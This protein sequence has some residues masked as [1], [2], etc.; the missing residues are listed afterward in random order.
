MTRPRATTT[1]GDDPATASR[2]PERP[3]VR[4]AGAV[5]ASRADPQHPVQRHRAA[6]PTTSPASTS[7]RCAPSLPFAA[8]R[9]AARG[10]GRRHA[11]WRGCSTRAPPSTRPRSSQSCWSARESRSAPRSA[12]AGSGVDLDVAKRRLAEAL[13]LLR[14]ALAEPVFPAVRG[15]PHRQDPARRDRAG[16]RPRPA[17]GGAGVHRHATSTR[18]TGP[19]VRRPAPPRAIAA[20]TRQDIVDFHA[21]R[22]GP[23]GHDRRRRRRPARASTWPTW[24]R[25]HAG[26][27]GQRHATSPAPEPRGAAARRGRGPRRLRRP[28]RVGAERAAGGVGRSG[29]A[30]RGR[31]GGIP[32]PGVHRRRL[33]QRARRRGAARGEGLHLRHPLGASGR[34]GV[35]GLFLTSGSVRADATVESV[36]LLLEIL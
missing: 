36:R 30:R 35:G 8:V 5:A 14:Q 33:A 26:L 15:G 18:T 20:L 9:R 34:V 31:L 25:R 23:T 1:A 7:S 29:P 2:R 11:S 21:R 19:P 28:A 3:E 32:G 16:A 22:V 24:S 6:W 27:L 13:D 17:A 4:A 12:T 10:R